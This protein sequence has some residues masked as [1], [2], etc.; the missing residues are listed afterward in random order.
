MPD[1]PYQYRQIELGLKLE[2][3]VVTDTCD[4]YPRQSSLPRPASA[5]ALRN[6]GA[7]NNV[8]P[9]LHDSW[10]SEWNGYYGHSTGVPSKIRPGLASRPGGNGRYSAAPSYGRSRSA[11]DGEF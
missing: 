2:V 8:R 4:I 11:Y 3:T 6:H 5:M 1:K 9:P 10:K 7:Y